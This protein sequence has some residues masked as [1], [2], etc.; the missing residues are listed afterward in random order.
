MLRGSVIVFTFHKVQKVEKK[1]VRTLIRLKIWLYKQTTN[2]KLLGSFI[3][4]LEQG[5]ENTYS[6]PKYHFPLSSLPV[7]KKT[8]NQQNTKTKR[9]NTISHHSLHLLGAQVYKS[10]SDFLIHKQEWNHHHQEQNHFAKAVEGYL[11]PHGT[12]SSLLRFT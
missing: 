5:T 9:F 12:E 6:P 11:T 4:P 8:P 10:L 3:S 2:G 7:W 1:W